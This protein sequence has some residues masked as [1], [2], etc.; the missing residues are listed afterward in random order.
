[1]EPA[2]GPFELALLGSGCLCALLTFLG[3]IGAVIFFIKKKQG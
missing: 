2:F 1:M 3:L